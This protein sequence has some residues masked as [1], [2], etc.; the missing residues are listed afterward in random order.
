MGFGVCAFEIGAVFENSETDRQAS[1]VGVE[2]ERPCKR[3]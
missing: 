3:A 1:V 2:I